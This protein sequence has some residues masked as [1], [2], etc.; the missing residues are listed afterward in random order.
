MNRLGG[1]TTSW[2]FALAEA[3]R[4]ITS[5]FVVYATSAANSKPVLWRGAVGRG[6]VVWRDDFLLCIRKTKS[7]GGGVEGLK[8]YYIV[9]LF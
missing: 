6:Q 2:R 9:L 5:H 3:L 4:K 7:E 1:V 8:L